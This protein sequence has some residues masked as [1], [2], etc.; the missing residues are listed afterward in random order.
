MN[1]PCSRTCRFLAAAVAVVLFLAVLPEAA[2][3]PKTP[4]EAS[5][6]SSCPDTIKV[7]QRITDLPPAWEAGLSDA[8]PGLMMVTFFDGPPAE[9]AS[10]KYDSEL[11]LKGNWVATWTFAANAHGYWIQ[12][13]Y[14]NTTVVLSR[15]LPETV[16]TCNVTY[17]RSTTAANG[18]P[19]VKAVSCADTLPKKPDEKK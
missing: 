13:V 18:L 6:S 15:R 9:R 4:A 19:L 8:R 17:E 2:A 12:C 7:E 10:L 5:G 16:R 11:R 1:S 3:Q 14:E